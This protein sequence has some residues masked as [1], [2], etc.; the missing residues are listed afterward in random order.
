MRYVLYFIL[1]FLTTYTDTPLQ[2]YFGA[3]GFS[4]L[5]ILSYIIYAIFI[6]TR[7][8][9]PDNKF[10][11][12]F[13]KL[14]NYTFII[15]IIAIL[16]V[17]IEGLPMD[18]KG[19]S[20]LTKTFNLYITFIGY[21]LFVIIISSITQKLTV[22]QIYSPFLYIFI[23]LSIYGY[24]EYKMIPNAFLNLHG[25]NHEYWRVRLLTAES[26]WTAPIL[27]IFF[28]MSFY[29]TF[30]I[31]KSKLLTLIVIA[32]LFYQISISSSKSFMIIILLSVIYGGWNYIL[33]VNRKYKFI[34]LLLSVFVVVTSLVVILPRLQNDMTYDLEE[35]TS[36]ATRFITI[37]AGLNVGIFLPFGSGFGT[38]LYLLPKSLNYI[39]SFFSNYGLNL[40]EMK[41][42]YFM[43]DSN[44][45][46]TAK[47]FLGQSTM[48]WG[49]L[50]SIYFFRKLFAF[51]KLSMQR[52][53]PNEQL[54]YKML[55]FIITINLFFMSDMEYL[56]LL[57]ISLLYRVSKNNV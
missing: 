24:F 6:L 54:I 4:C 52:I 11:K 47:S 19:T 8:Q 33:K 16:I 43:S 50:G 27:E 7:R 41:T 55:L 2:K 14:I 10:A 37:L 29:F 39:F 23:I 1:V 18:V 15:S 25:V 26:S 31:K 36:F 51:F 35:S 53:N 46:M 5:P 21:V 13:I 12:D 3:F 48:Y 44:T 30:Y 17:A 40:N 49:I 57:V 45:G 34:T 9:I 20:I 28:L 32:C 42:I 56:Y 22:N 38:Y